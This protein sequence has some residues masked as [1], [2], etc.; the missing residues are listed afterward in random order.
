MIVPWSHMLLAS[1]SQ[2]ALLA[3]GVGAGGGYPLN[4]LTSGNRFYADMSITSYATS[5]KSTLASD[6]GPVLAVEDMSP[7]QNDLTGVGSATWNETDGALVLDGDSYFDFG[8]TYFLSETG[9]TIVAR[10]KFDAGVG[11]TQCICGAINASPYDRGWLSVT[12]GVASM[13]VGQDGSNNHKDDTLTDLRGDGNYHVLA[14][15]WDG[16]EGRLFVDG[17]LVH[18]FTR[19]TG[20]VT[21]VGAAFGGRSRGGPPPDLEL[22][23]RVSHLLLDARKM[24]DPEIAGLSTAWTP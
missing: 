17:A 20:A 12:D 24:T 2:G 9:Q 7:G 1:V 8:T 14:A 16:T 19:S 22:K 6:G 15:V 13:A 18:S 11:G 5:D 21:T 4:L 23:G 10:V 3:G